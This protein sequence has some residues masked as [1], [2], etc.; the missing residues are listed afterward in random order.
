[1]PELN[2]DLMSLEDFL[3]E[4]DKTPNRVRR[5]EGEGG[6][7]LYIYRMARDIGGE[8]NLAD[9]QLYERTAK[10]NSANAYACTRLYQACTE[11]PPN[12]N[13]PIMGGKA[14]PPNITPANIS[15]SMVICDAGV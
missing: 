9:W 5:R 8:F 15:C 4:S 12:Y 6:L 3:A 14:N 11:T 7:A 10:L 1:M 13:P 2:E